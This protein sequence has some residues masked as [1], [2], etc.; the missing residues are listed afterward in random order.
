MRNR[1]SMPP[2][3]HGVPVLP[4]LLPS[5]HPGPLSPS[6]LLMPPP[7]PRE[8][9]PAPKGAGLPRRP[10]DYNVAAQ[11][12]ARSRQAQRLHRARSQEVVVAAAAAPPGYACEVAGPDLATE[13]DVDEEDEDETQ[14]SAV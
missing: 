1:K 8:P 13:Q 11:M 14:V 3:T 2:F 6:C 7:P 12:A 9:P 5:Q 10:P 4:P